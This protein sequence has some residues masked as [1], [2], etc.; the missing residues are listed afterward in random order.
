MTKCPKPK[1]LED[2]S[3]DLVP[4]AEK[5]ICDKCGEET[6][7]A[8]PRQKTKGRHPMCIPGGTLDRATEDHETRAILDILAA[9]PGTTIEEA[10]LN[11][12]PMDVGYDGEGAGPCALCRGSIRRYGSGGLPLCKKCDQERKYG[13]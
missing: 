7:W 8:A 9:F 3:E 1:I 4:L 6:M 2:Y 12:G 13:G 10:K 11:A 5:R